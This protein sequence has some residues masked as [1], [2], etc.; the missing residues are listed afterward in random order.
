MRRRWALLMMT[1][2]FAIA[3]APPPSFLLVQAQAQSPADESKRRAA[4]LDARFIEL[5]AA[6][7]DAEAEPIVGEIWTLWLQSGRGDVDQLMGEAMRV[8]QR[9]G[10]QLALSMLDEV[11]KRAP[12]YAEGWNRRATLLYF[13]GEYERSKADCDEVLK[14][15]PRHFGALAGMGLIGIAQSDFKAALAAYRRAVAVN[16]FLKDRDQVIPALVKKVEG[17]R[18]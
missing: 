1:A 9:G 18:L 12:D 15:E 7:S 13:M 8:M 4:E 5:K 14:R 10:Q 3:V 17:E 16:P 2:V 11:V 6:K